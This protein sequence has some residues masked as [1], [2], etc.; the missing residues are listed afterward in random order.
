MPR[1]VLFQN[2]TRL[3]SNDLVFFSYQLYNMKYCFISVILFISRQVKQTPQFVGII[4]GINKE[5]KVKHSFYLW[6]KLDCTDVKTH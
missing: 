1:N 3:L 4:K 5:K 6:T 2:L